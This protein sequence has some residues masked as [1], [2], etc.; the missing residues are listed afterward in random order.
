MEIWNNLFNAFTLFTISAIF[1][2]GFIVK[3]EGYYIAGSILGL[4]FGLLLFLVLVSSLISGE[5]KFSY[6]IF[7]L[8]TIPYLIKVKK[9]YSRA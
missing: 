9:I 1:L 4:I 8:C 3:R 5:I 2:K 6:G 7:G